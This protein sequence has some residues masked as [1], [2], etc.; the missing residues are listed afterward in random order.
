MLTTL[1]HEQRISQ[2]TSTRLYSR[3][4]GLPWLKF[5]RQRNS[6]KKANGRIAGSATRY[7]GA[8]ARPCGIAIPASA[9]FVKAST[10][11]SRTASVNASLA[12]SVKLT[13]EPDDD[14]QVDIPMHD[15]RG[16][17]LPSADHKTVS[18][19]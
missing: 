9:V 2:I 8:G 16:R 4:R 10:G 15:R 13:N 12:A 6:L 14:P 1:H 7:F 18:Q 17:H 5:L 11:T 3:L 19:P